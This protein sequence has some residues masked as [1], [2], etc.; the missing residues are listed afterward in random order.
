[1][2]FLYANTMRL[3]K[4][5]IFSANRALENYLVAFDSEDR[6][7]ASRYPQEPEFPHTTHRHPLSVSEQTSQFAA[8]E[9]HQRNQKHE[10]QQEFGEVSHRSSVYTN[11]A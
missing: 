1:M 5:I 7:S 3:L 6:P 11:M 9:P 8:G 10:A 4:R 2:F